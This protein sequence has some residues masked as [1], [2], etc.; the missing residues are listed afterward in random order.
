MCIISQSREYC[1]RVRRCP[2]SY[3]LTTTV[4]TWPY[5][6]YCPVLNCQIHISVLGINALYE[7]LVFSYGWWGGG[8]ALWS[9]LGRHS[10][11][12]R[13]MERGRPEYHDYYNQ[14]RLG[15]VLSL[16]I[17][18]YLSIRDMDIGRVNVNPT[19]H[20][21]SMYMSVEPGKIFH[22][23]GYTCIYVC[24]LTFLTF[25]ALTLYAFTFKKW[26]TAGY[27]LN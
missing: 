14:C 6:F 22:I 20:S 18:P 9:Q 10:V 3:G 19:C 16:N 7:V 13:E 4:I 15:L 11:L 1:V 24:I 27:K 23:H 21:H 17:N 12:I 5:T 8:R 2:Q 26:V 25:K